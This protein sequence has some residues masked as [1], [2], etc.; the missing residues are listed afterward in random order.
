MAKDV[1][2]R[3]G[4]RVPEGISISALAVEESKEYLTDLIRVYAQKIFK[5]I[6]PPW[7]I[8]PSKGSLSLGIHIARSYDEL[9]HAITLFLESDC[10]MIIE[11][12]ITGKEITVGIIEGVRDREHYVFV[13]HELVSKSQ[14]FDMQA[15]TSGAYDLRPFSNKAVSQDLQEIASKLFAKLGLR[16]TAI[17]DFIVSPKGV[18]ILEVDTVPEWHKNA[19]IHR[20]M[21]ATGV[22]MEE[23]LKGLVDSAMGKSK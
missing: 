9:E 15:R 14:Y 13:P 10:D 18:Y 5:T 11:E 12:Y 3:L 22:T 16:H 1:I 8:K 20:L 7:I 23:C 6:P 17:F 2:A 21:S 4:Y 19:P